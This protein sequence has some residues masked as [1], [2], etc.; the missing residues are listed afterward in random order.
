MSFDILNRDELVLIFK[1]L[2]PKSVVNLCNSSSKFRNFCNRNNI[3]YLAM[4]ELSKLDGP[5]L[6]RIQQYSE[7]YQVVMFCNLNPGFRR[8]CNRDGF[9]DEMIKY[10]YPNIHVP[11]EQS[12][13]AY[14]ENTT[15]TFL[16][17]YSPFGE[18]TITNHEGIEFTKFEDFK[19]TTYLV[20]NG[21]WSNGENTIGLEIPAIHWDREY[22]WVAAKSNI[23]GLNVSAFTSKEDA[24]RSF[25][26]NFTN[27][28]DLGY[29]A[30]DYLN[31]ISDLEMN[32][33][34]N[35]SDLNIEKYFNLFNYD[36]DQR[37]AYF[38]PQ[39]EFDKLHKMGYPQ[40]VEYE[41]LAQAQERLYQYI[42]RNNFFSYGIKVD[43]TS[44]QDPAMVEFFQ[45]FEVRLI[46]ELDPTLELDEY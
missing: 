20:P 15:I 16:L 37:I 13:R 3:W 14:L 1:N 5:N 44:N 2:D 45:V 36:E 6:A 34:Y 9:W 35:D 31:E 38:I 17:E 12:R 19:N 29:L 23:N 18:V 39:S 22:I 24:V 10:H 41:S 27:F 40:F 42:M 28:K 33:I 7:P 21:D 8:L 25:T 46:K 30:Q 32:L 43:F 26:S 11:I 4:G